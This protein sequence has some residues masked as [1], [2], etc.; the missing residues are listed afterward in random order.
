LDR[1]G[2]TLI[3]SQY[4]VTEHAKKYDHT[5]VAGM[6]GIFLRYNLSALM[7]RVTE[8]R[9]SVIFFVVRVFGILGGMWKMVAMGL[10]FLTRR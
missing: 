4:A 1:H 10:T 2:N 9:G 3:T 6:P 8:G 7:V 5:Q